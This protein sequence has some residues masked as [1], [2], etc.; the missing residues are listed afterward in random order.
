MDVLCELKGSMVSNNIP[1]SVYCQPI[2]YNT[3]YL[4][5]YADM[6]DLESCVNSVDENYDDFITNILYILDGTV[7]LLSSLDI[8]KKVND[9]IKQLSNN[10]DSKGALR[11]H[12][13]RWHSKKLD[14]LKHEMRMHAF[15]PKS[16]SDDM[17]FY[18]T[19]YLST[20]ICILNYDSCT[21]KSIS[22]DRFEKGVIFIVCQNA[23]EIAHNSSPI[24]R[25]FNIN[26][27]ERL[28][29][30]IENES[31]LKMKHINI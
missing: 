31:N 1:N 5:P 4:N 2:N 12:G 17:L 18:L 6:I 27:K 16:I 22:W 10:I 24:D 13:V 19:L 21:C 11:H 7:Q 9:F 15:S 23:I 8:S 28:V 29:T 25:Y 3:V 30:K 26:D 14:K 20:S